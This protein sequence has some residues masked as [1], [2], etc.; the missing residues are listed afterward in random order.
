[1]QKTRTRKIRALQAILTIVVLVSL[2]IPVGY[3]IAE[4][5]GDYGTILTD[6]GYVVGDTYQRHTFIAEDL[7]WVFYA[8]DSAIY[9]TSSSDVDTWETP[10]KFDDYTCNLSP[11]EC[12]N[13]SAFSLWYNLGE[14]RVD[15]AFMNITG[16]NENIYYQRGRPESDGTIAWNN[17]QVAVPA[18]ANLTYSHPSICD[19]SLDYPFIAYM[20]YNGSNY[21]GNLSTSTTNDSTWTA[22]TNSTISSSISFNISTDV[23]YPSVIPVT[24]GNV[25]LQVAFKNLADAYLLGQ[26][27]ADYD[28]DTDTWAYPL[29]AQFPLPATSYLDVSDLSYHSEIAWENA[30]NPDDVYMIATAND[31]VL[32]QYLWWDRYGDTGSPWADDGAL[33]TGY[34]AGSIGIRNA[35]GDLSVTAIELT[36]KTQLYNWDYDMTSMTWGTANAID[37]VDATSWLGPESDYDNAGT[38]YLGT[39]YYD[40]IVA[41]SPDLEYGC[42]GCTADT[43]P[44]TI[45]ASVTLMAWIVI[46]VFGALVCLVLLAYGGYETIKGRGNT[47]L[48][49][50]GAIGF[51]TF[52]IAAIIVENLL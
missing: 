41:F 21:S 4:S 13:G 11:E 17:V 33:D 6:T 28:I 47:D 40:N 22:A 37:G 51:I 26:N 5:F 39:I 3:A 49:K 35:L 9:Y 34:Y 43:T 23:L 10:T 46:L 45:P 30:S 24:A 2:F 50:I 44:S 12:C 31:S 15:I 42:Y 38:N 19:N 36:Q 25:S 29:P 27:Y 32:G 16:Q 48:M 52:V 7:H 14:N 18:D 8:T 1:M 20:V